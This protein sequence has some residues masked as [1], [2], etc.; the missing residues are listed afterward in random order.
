LKWAGTLLI[1]I[2]GWVFFRATNISHAFAYLGD[3]FN[4]T[5]YYKHINLEDIMVVDT[6]GV[7][8]F[9]IAAIICFI[10]MFKKPY[11]MLTDF[12]N[13]RQKLIAVMVFALLCFSLLKIITA[14]FSPFIYFMF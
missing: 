9:L 3:M 12:F 13:H 10:P 4:F 6:R 7:F 5:N 1:V 11:A 14:Q 8:T 2:V